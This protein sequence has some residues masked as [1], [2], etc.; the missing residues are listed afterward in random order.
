M[1]HNK[2]FKVDHQNVLLKFQKKD[3]NTHFYY[4]QGILMIFN[5]KKLWCHLISNLNI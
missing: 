2:L 4:Q 1:E 5:H 3:K